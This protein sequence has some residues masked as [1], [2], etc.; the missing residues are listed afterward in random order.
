VSV[1]LLLTVRERGGERGERGRGERER[2]EKE[3]RGRKNK[4]QKKNFFPFLISLPLFFP[5]RLR[6]SYLFSARF[7]AIA[8]LWFRSGKPQFHPSQRKEKREEEEPPR[9]RG[10]AFRTLLTV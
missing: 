5:F 2:K 7:T 10:P 9:Q 8:F 3:T 1:E 6:L 4:M